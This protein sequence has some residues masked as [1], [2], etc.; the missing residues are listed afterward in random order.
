MK[1]I[2]FYSMLFAAAAAVSACSDDKKGDEPNDG[3]DAKPGDV[4]VTIATSNIETKAAKLEFTA[5][6]AMN[7]FAKKYS[8]ASSEDIVSKIKATYDGTK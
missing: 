7:V 3:G 2:Y 5:N 1:K 8:D 6:D 4:E